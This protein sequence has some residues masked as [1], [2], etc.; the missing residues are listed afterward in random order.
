MCAVLLCWLMVCTFNNI[1]MIKPN[2][3]QHIHVN[4]AH[5]SIYTRC[6]LDIL[7]VYTYA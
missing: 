7:C 4:T 1:G 5:L 6:T 2:Q 3:T